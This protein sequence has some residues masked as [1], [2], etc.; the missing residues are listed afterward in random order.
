MVSFDVAKHTVVVLR[1]LTGRDVFFSK[2]LDFMS[3]YRL[4]NPQL[5]DVMPEGKLSGDESWS[6]FMA[7]FIRSEVLEKLYP[8]LIEDA[9][10]LIAMWG[11]DGTL[12]PFDKVYELV[13]A[14][15]MRMTTCNEWANDP[16]KIKKIRD[17]FAHI[18]AGSTPSSIILPWIPT[19]ARV[20]R[21]LAGA[22]LYRMVNDVV[23]SRKREGRHEDD[24]MQTLID[25]DFT[26]TQIT[27]FT[28]MTL[29]A[30]ATNTGNVL[31]WML[32]YL[33]A[34]QD[35]KSKI[36]DEIR[37]YTKGSDDVAAGLR[38]PSTNRPAIDLDDET[39]GLGNCIDETL[40]LLFKGTFMRRNIGDDVYA[41]GVCIEN[42]TFLMYPT[43]DLHYDPTLYPDPNRFN[44]TRWDADAVAD[45]KKYGITFLGWGAARHVCVG[46]RAA[47]LMMRIITTI[48]L[49]NFEVEMVDKS[50]EPMQ[51]VPQL[52]NDRLFKVTLPTEMVAL[53]YRKKLDV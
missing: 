44:P 26:L 30:A 52:R 9:A 3:G 40:R 1:G 6:G 23:S 5:V 8:T 49:A 51:A 29:F 48:I 22:K 21:F 17:I 42:G 47:R 37:S 31:C 34:N 24:P 4:L 14:L 16:Q 35:W 28:A 10:R 19:L 53:R 43:G 2:G 25:K 38:L 7:T 36:K 50:G 20:K 46:K 11:D 32:L 18:E 33:E 15:S 45:R 12:D 27:R 13:F 39:P 41:S